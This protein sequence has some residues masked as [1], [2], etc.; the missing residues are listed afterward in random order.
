M[1]QA[2]F[3]SWGRVVRAAHESVPVV[4]R[5]TPITIPAGLSALP[6]GLGR[7]YGDSCLN[8]G[9]ALLVTVGLDR[10]IAFD[11]GQGI[12]R[13]EAGVTLADVLAVAV[14]RGWFL[15]VTPGTKHVTVGGAI[16]NDVHGKNHHRAGTFGRHVRRLELLRSDGSRLVCSPA[17]NP[18]WFGATIGGLGLTGLITWAEISLHPVATAGIDAESIRFESLDEF[19]AIN[20]ESE[21]SFVYTVA[22]ID[23]LATGRRLG[24]G[25]YFRGNHAPAVDR[26]P[27]AAR[28][29]PIRVPLDAPEWLL[30]RLT[31]GAFNAVYYHRQRRRVR[32]SIVHYE[33]F[34]Y[35]LDVVDSWNRL[36]G[37]RGF[38]QYQ[39]VVPF[40]E[41]HTAVEDILEATA[42]SRQGSFL[43]ILK[44]FGDLPSPGW[45][46]FPRPGY[47]LTVDFPNRGESTRALFDRLDG[48]VAA[49]GGALYPAKDARMSAHLFRQSFPNWPRFAEYVDPRFSSSF[50][51]RVTGAGGENVVQ[52]AT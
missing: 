28:H 22:W 23:A 9:G 51:R 43:A 52:D 45:L 17:E 5:S 12:L 6:Y 21:A 14:P 24:R 44:S 31:L 32:R 41:G 25:R 46:S 4:W 42:R 29:G 8:E 37:R 33:P 27:P 2:M 16:A 20:R 39:C 50:W 15:P 26:L 34:F 35:P 1:P 18:D 40:D 19:F 30:N 36:Y 49:C 13:C 3:T 11:A 48:I 47:T 38:F 7:S 10:L